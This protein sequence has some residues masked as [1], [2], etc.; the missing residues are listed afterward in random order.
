[1]DADL[2]PLSAL[3]CVHLRL[4]F[5]FARNARTFA[6]LL[7]MGR[8]DLR[9]QRTVCDSLRYG[10]WRRKYCGLFV[11]GSVTDLFVPSSLTLAEYGSWPALIL[12]FSPGRRNSMARL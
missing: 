6:I 9:T 7:Q 5:F 11:A 2:S 8:R 4:K 1:M 12:T 3:V 10:P